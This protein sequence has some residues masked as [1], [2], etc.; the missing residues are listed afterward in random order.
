[1][2]TTRAEAISRVRNTIKAVNQDAFIT[3]RFIYSIIIKYAKT[4]IARQDSEN[5]IMKFQSLFEAIPCLELIE[6]DK[7]E[8]CCSG[9]KTNCTIRRSK[10][11]LPEVFEGTYGPLFRSITS[12]DRSQQVYKTYPETFTSIANSTNYKYNTNKYYWYIEG[13]LY[14]PNL[15][16][17]GVLVEGLWTDSIDYLK[18]NSKDC[19]KAQ[20]M[21]IHI[22]EKLFSEIDQL[23]SRDFG[24]LI[25]MPAEKETDKESPLRT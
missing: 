24:V 15:E 17:D 9:I 13:Y 18:C 3:D 12:L 4:F 8:A 6:I 19:V 21:E 5:K 11:K 25:Q 14:F 10:D 1:M 7:V 22:P 23:I 2:S 16:W 20:Y